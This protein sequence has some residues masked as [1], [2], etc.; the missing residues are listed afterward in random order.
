MIR[1][2]FVNSG[3]EFSLMNVYAPCDSSRQQS[4]WQNI[5]S[6]LTSLLDHGLC[7]CGDFNTV[8]SREERRSVGNVGIH[9]GSDFFN[10]FI[11]MNSLIDLPL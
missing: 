6:R 7:V 10:Q 5:S 11:G 9:A 2:R 1:G 4:I 8:R 3:E